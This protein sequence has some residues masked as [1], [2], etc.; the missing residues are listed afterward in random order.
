MSSEGM[1]VRAEHGARARGGVSGVL[2]LCLGVDVVLLFSRNGKR[3]A[4]SAF[5]FFPKVPPKE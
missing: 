3:I 5:D 2:L 4:P 1:A